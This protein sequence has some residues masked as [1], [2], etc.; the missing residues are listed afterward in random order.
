MNQILVQSQYSHRSIQKSSIVP[1]LFNIS[2]KALTVK[3]LVR[4]VIN[5]NSVSFSS[6]VNVILFF[7]MVGSSL[8]LLTDLGTLGPATSGSESTLAVSPKSISLELD[9]QLNV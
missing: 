7:L 2:W 6:S 1:V 5:R 4:L 8:S 9:L 3:G